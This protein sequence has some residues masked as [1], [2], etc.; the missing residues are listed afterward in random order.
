MLILG[1]LIGVD[2]ILVITSCQPRV[3]SCHSPKLETGNLDCFCSKYPIPSAIQNLNE[4]IGEFFNGNI[5]G[6]SLSRC[7]SKPYTVKVLLGD[8]PQDSIINY[9]F[10]DFVTG[11]L[12]FNGRLTRYITVNV[13]NVVGGLIVKGSLSCNDLAEKPNLELNF[14]N[15][16]SIEVSNFYVK[17]SLNRCNVSFNVNDAEEF[18]VKDSRIRDVNNNVVADNCDLNQNSVNCSDVFME[19]KD[20]DDNTLE[21]MLGIIVTLTCVAILVICLQ[22]KS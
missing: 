13:N 12:I 15:V 7:G 5:S 17:R 1:L 19:E 11:K 21:I 4:Q 6:V 10:S 3:F 20:F 2:L 8:S 22:N 18:R 9:S 16:K 14:F